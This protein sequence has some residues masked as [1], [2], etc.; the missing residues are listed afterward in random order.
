MTGW[1]DAGLIVYDEKDMKNTRVGCY[2]TLSCLYSII[3]RDVR[4]HMER[5]GVYASV[6]YRHLMKEHPDLLEPLNHELDD[7]YQDLYTL[8]DIGRAFVPVRFQNKAGGLTD[9]EYAQIKQHT[10]L[11]A[12][13]LDSI[14]ILPFTDSVKMRLFNI[15]MYHHERY[16]GKGYP[17]GIAQ[18]Q[19][20]LEARIC[21]LA[22]AY[23]GMTSWK[24]YRKNMPIEKVR[25]IILEEAGKQFT[26]SLSLAFVECM[27]Q[28]PK[29][30]LDEAW[31][32]HAGRY[33]GRDLN[34]QSG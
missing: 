12:D 17:F 3:P 29:D 26:P 21:S 9:E 2:P 30:E 20:P 6:F 8:H 27:D 28:M 22:D 16:D 1:G 25:M 15:S 19:I 32:A 14:Y 23:D 18:E 7:C 5:V 24:P 13:T 34:I 4:L 11:T 31:E 10:V 33:F